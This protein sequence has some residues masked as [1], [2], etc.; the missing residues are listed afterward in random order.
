MD[1]GFGKADGFQR[2]VLSSERYQERYRATTVKLEC[3]NIQT[4]VRTGE[5]QACLAVPRVP[6]VT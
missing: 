2:P 4:S 3:W 5:G 1:R 6:A